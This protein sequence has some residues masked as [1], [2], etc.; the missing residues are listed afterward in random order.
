MVNLSSAAARSH[1]FDEKSLRLTLA[2]IARNSY[3]GGA[4][5]NQALGAGWRLGIDHAMADGILS[6]PGKPP[7]K[8]S[9]KTD[10]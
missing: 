5:V 8:A 1:N 6:T 9:W 2:E 10:Y 4:S 7:W 3:G